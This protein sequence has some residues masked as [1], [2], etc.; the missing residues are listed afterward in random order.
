MMNEKQILKVLTE[1]EDNGGLHINF[2]G[3]I[4]NKLSNTDKVVASG[5]ALSMYGTGK[6]FIENLSLEKDIPT[7]IHNEMVQMKAFGKKVELI[8]RKVK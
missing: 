6:G 3:A 4:A 5:E 2:K 8:L 7:L 1:I